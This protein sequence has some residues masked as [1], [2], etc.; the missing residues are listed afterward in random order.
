MQKHLWL[1]S[2]HHFFHRNIITYQN[3][4][5]SSIEEMH[6]VMIENHNKCVKTNEVCYF[7]G[8]FSLGS[9]Q[10]TQSVINRLNGNLV[11]I[12]GSHDYW[13]EEM[14][15]LSFDLPISLNGNE[16][17]I[18]NSIHEFRHYN[19]FIVLCHYA[20][21]TW[22]K[23]HYG[24]YHFYGHSHGHIEDYGNSTD[25]SIERW[26]YKPIDLEYLINIYDFKYKR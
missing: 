1:T 23:S 12:P 22:P 25:L 4:P 8:D 20:M 16:I 9:F 7:V 10:D 14:N 5:F 2:D 19:K 15:D 24:S 26:N 18:A 21:R 11:F 3:R 6:E 17:V 13:I